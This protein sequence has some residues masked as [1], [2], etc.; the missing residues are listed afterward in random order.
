M[1]HRL[2]RTGFLLLILSLSWH[3]G[4]TELVF[5]DAW[6]SEAPPVARSQAAYMHIHNA[7]EQDI[8]IVAVKAE[9]YGM[10]MMHKTVMDGD[11]ASMEHQDSLLI[12]A[13]GNV[14]LSPGG[15][16]I[17]LMSPERILS[18]GEKTA[19]TF[20]YSDGSEQQISAE[21]KAA[22]TPIHHH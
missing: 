10:V 4:A 12:P 21:V 2:F 1:N 8:V 13:Q 19:M 5:H 3:A 7:T 20:T 18:L 15:I 11:M 17:M 14:V 22:D 9:G 16:H 6:V